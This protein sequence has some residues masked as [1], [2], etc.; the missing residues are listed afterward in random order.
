MRTIAVAS[1]L[2]IGLCACA[3]VRHAGDVGVECTAVAN[4]TLRNCRV[5]SENPQGKGL[6]ELALNIAEGR[7]VDPSYIVGG[8]GRVVFT[9]RVQT[10]D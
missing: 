9:I 3:T 8:S 4:G 2:M 6:G 10:E 1:W 7:K 5:I